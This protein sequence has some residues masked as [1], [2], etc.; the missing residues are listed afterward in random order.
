M[1]HSVSDTQTVEA[2][3]AIRSISPLGWGWVLGAGL[4][5]A[6]IGSALAALGAL[7]G[8]GAELRSGIEDRSTQLVQNVHPV[9]PA[10][11]TKGTTG[12]TQTRMSGAEPVP[13][14]PLQPGD[15][16]PL[17]IDT[18]PAVP[19]QVGIDWSPAGDSVANGS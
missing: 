9:P 1:S 7:G 4:G 6:T 13:L 15:L 11:G 17:E 16:R 8:N 2:A 12:A 5:L 14:L 18:A 10:E 19:A 3:Q